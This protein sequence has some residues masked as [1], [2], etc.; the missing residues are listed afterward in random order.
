MR[1]GVAWNL[2]ALASKAPFADGM[3]SILCVVSP[4]VCGLVWLCHVKT[5]VFVL[6]LC[7]YVC[8]HGLVTCILYGLGPSVCGL[9]Q[10]WDMRARVFALLLR[11][12]ACMYSLVGCIGY[13]FRFLGVWFSVVELYRV[14]AV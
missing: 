14:I 6:L 10:F 8:V 4:S 1:C 13:G 2:V 9:V 12:C 7:F 11:V 3:L 5:R